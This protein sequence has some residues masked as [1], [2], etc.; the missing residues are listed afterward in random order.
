MILALLAAS[1]PAQEPGNLIDNGSFERIDDRALPS[2]WRLNTW[3]G[4]AAFAVEDAFAHSGKRCVKISSTDGGDAS[5]S[6]EVQVAP[7]TR[8]RLSAWVKVKGLDKRGG[9]GAQLNLHELQREGKTEAIHGD[10][11]WTQLVSTFDSGNRRSLLVNLLFGGW[12]R[13][14]GE[15]WFD[16]VELVDLTPPLPQ[17]TARARSVWRI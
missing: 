2:G 9:Y 15:A 16:D 6:F 3:S 5:F 14:V 11:G 8:Y 17:M 13:S 12:G 1:A 7:Q 10:R 4:K